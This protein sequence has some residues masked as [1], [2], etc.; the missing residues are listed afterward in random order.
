MINVRE[1]DPL[2]L[3]NLESKERK[4]Q[5]ERDRYA[6]RTEEQREEINK[7]RREI[8]DQQKEERNKKRREAYQRKKAQSTLTAE[9]HNIKERM[10]Y[11]NMDPNKKASIHEERKKRRRVLKEL[12]RNTLNKESIA[13]ENPMYVPEVVPLS[14]NETGSQGT[15]VTSPRDWA[16]PELNESPI[17]VQSAEEEMMDYELPDMSDGSILRRKHVTYGE[18]QALLARQIQKF[19]ASCA[20]NRASALMEEDTTMSGKFHAH[21]CIFISIQS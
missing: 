14:I 17:Y 4:R 2:E 19:E 1:M 9:S 5:R 20:K 6:K 11:A 7:K 10:R 16:I 21:A 13:L 12:Q 15:K 3:N 8:S 18:R